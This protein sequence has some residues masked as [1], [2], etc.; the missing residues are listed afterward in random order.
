MRASQKSFS[1]PQSKSELEL[2]KVRVEQKQ[3][4]RDHAQTLLNRTQVRAERG[5]IAVFSDANEWLG[6]PV[7]VGQR[8]LSLADPEQ[9]EIQLWLAVADGINLEPGARVQF[10]LNTAPASP[11]AAQLRQ[12]SYEPEQN[13]A[14][15]VAFRLKA[16]LMATQPTP[17]IGLQGTAKVFGDEV[18]LF[19]YVMRRPLSVLR[20]TFGF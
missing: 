5:G 19:Y 7:E 15:G 17:R 2:Y 10:F 12:T 20:Q 14:G 16:S 4:E 6:R 18:S 3:L 8:I 11:L 1:D 13:P 9:A